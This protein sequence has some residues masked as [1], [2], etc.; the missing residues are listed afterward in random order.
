MFDSMDC[1]EIT[2]ESKDISHQN[3][4][5]RIPVLLQ[6]SIPGMTRVCLKL[7]VTGQHCSKLSPERGQKVLEAALSSAENYLASLGVDTERLPME[8]EEEW[9]AETGDRSCSSSSSSD[10]EFSEGA[11]HAS[12]S[13][14]DF[15]SGDAMS[16][17]CGTQDRLPHAGT[18]SI[19]KHA[20]MG[21]EANETSARQPRRPSRLRKEVRFAALE[22]A[23][24]TSSESESEAVTTRVTTPCAESVTR[25]SPPQCRAR[26]P[27]KPAFRRFRKASDEAQPLAAEHE[28]ETWQA[29]ESGSSQCS[30]PN[31]E[32]E[33]APSESVA[34]A[35]NS[36]W[37]STGGNSGS[38]RLPVGLRERRSKTATAVVPSAKQPQL[39]KQHLLAQRAGDQAS[40]PTVT[41]PGADPLKIFPPKDLPESSAKAPIVV[42]PAPPLAMRLLQVARPAKRSLFSDNRLV[43]QRVEPELDAPEI[44]KTI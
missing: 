32:Q 16:K 7:D 39:E 13:K 5:A 15:S 4:A 18:N 6:L 30:Q 2:A 42:N 41:S 25:P 26:P 9:S 22:R 11:H 8:R 20:V 27:P 38:P 34:T 43:C 37:G 21:L 1:D 3:A 14:D 23:E 36:S 44:T 33:S 31:P 40:N 28:A 24:E 35:W 10:Q 12:C 19:L 29:P 17:A